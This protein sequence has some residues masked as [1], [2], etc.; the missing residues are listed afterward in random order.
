LNKIA[1]WSIILIGSFFLISL[2]ANFGGFGGWF[3]LLIQGPYITLMFY[4]FYRVLSEGT[5][6][7][8]KRGILLDLLLILSLMIFFVGYGMHFTANH[9]EVLMAENEF[10][11]FITPKVATNPEAIIYL[12]SLYTPTYYFDEMLGHQLIYTG[13]F[14]LMIGGILLESWF[15]G[16]EEL[17][18]TDYMAVTTSSILFTVIIVL[19]TVEGQYAIHALVLTVLMA[20]VLL[21]YFKGGIVKR[22]F[23]LF[24]LLTSI[25]SAVYIS[26]LAAMYFDVISATL[27]GLLGRIPQFSEPE[28]ILRQFIFL[29]GVFGDEVKLLLSFIL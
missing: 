10:M 26:L 22:P 21:A 6:K 28:R 3:D 15:R 20:A 11:L 23:C 16:E 4:G 24:M 7:T 12:Y 19:A 8:G 1:K 14:G 13:F 5:S 29:S 9:I 25:M 27:H 18:R 2:A 17:S